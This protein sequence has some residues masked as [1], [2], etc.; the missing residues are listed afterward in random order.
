M[1]LLVQVNGRNGALMSSKYEK[2][3]INSKGYDRWA[4]VYDLYPNPT[5]AIDELTFPDLWKT[6]RGKHVLE[7]GCGTGR[8][9]EKLVAAENTVTALDLSAG[10]LAVARDKLKDKPVTFLESDFMNCNDLPDGEFDAALAS[11]VVEHIREVDAFFEKVLRVLNP[12]SDFYLSEIHPTRAAQGRLAH[13]SDA[14]TNEEVRFDSHPHSQ[15][16]IETAAARAQF[17]LVTKR[18]VL[19]DDRLV[20]ANPAWSKYLGVPMI[21]IWHFRK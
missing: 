20:N 4:S 12:G 2:S 15:E 9:T 18:D 10:M 8:H 6:L 5:V 14:Q 16:Q 17:S 21:Q 13:F 3:T 1:P 19:G 11:L 7:I